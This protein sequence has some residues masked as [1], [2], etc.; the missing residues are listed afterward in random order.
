MQYLFMIGGI[1]LSYT[2][3]YLEDLADKYILEKM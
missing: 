3:V 2:S 1:K